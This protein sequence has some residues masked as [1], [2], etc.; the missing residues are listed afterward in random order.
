MIA[1]AAVACATA[2]VPAYAA[3][4]S[5]TPTVPVMAAAANGVAGQYMVTVKRPSR[6]SQ[7]IGFPTVHRFSNG[8]AARLS[9]A[10]LKKLQSDPNVA[11]I[12][13]DQIVRIDTTQ[14]SPTWGLDRIDQTKLP[15]SHSY[16]YKHTGSGVD[17]Y[18][19]DTGI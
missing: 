12:E 3:V 19:I 17:A 2:T 6:L 11:A 15:L 9:A 18:V 8:F 14:T 7:S 16:T 10:Q 5:P 13:Q 4:T 1:S